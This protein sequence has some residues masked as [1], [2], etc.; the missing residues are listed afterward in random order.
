MSKQKQNLSHLSHYLDL[1][2][3]ASW[4]RNGEVKD[5][6]G[7]KYTLDGLI[8]LI[9]K[10]NINH[11]DANGYTALMRACS[12]R[13][14]NNV[15]LLIKAGAD[16]N[17]VGS[18]GM[19]A[20]IAAAE[21]NNYLAIQDLLGV[22]AGANIDHVDKYGKTALRAAFEKK[23]GSSILTLL[24]AGADV[25]SEPPYG[26]TFLAVAAEI[27]DVKIISTLLEK[28]LDIDEKGGSGMTPLARAA[29][30]GNAAAVVA[31]ANKGADI[32]K[33]DIYGSNPLMV[34]A[35]NSE[36]YKTT[37][38]EDLIMLGVDINQK[39]AEGE[40]A[41]MVASSRG[42]VGIVKKL[43]SLGASVN[44][45]DNNGETAFMKSASGWEVK[46]D[47]LTI[48]L[49]N[50]A[51][52]SLQNNNGSTALGLTRGWYGR[53]LVE[54]TV[55]KTIPTKKYLI[56][57]KDP[58]NISH[59][60]GWSG[61]IHSILES[62]KNKELSKLPFAKLNSDSSISFFVATPVN[63]DYFEEYQ[64]FN[65]PNINFR[66]AILSN[67]FIEQFEHQAQEY[68]LEKIGANKPLIEK[69]P[70]ATGEV[71]EYC[72]NISP[73]NLDSILKLNETYAGYRNESG[74]LKLRE[75]IIPLKDGKIRLFPI[76]PIS[77]E[78]YAVRAD[79]CQ[80]SEVPTL[81]LMQLL[82]NYETEI[83]PDHKKNGFHFHWVPEEVEKALSIE[84]GSFVRFLNDFFKENGIKVT[85]DGRDF[86]ERPDT[87]HIEESAKQKS[88]KIVEI[89][90]NSK[91]F[92]AKYGNCSKEELSNCLSFEA[93]TLPFLQ[94]L[95]GFLEKESANG[96]EA[97]QE[98][99]L[100]TLSLMIEK[101]E[102]RIK[103]EK[104]KPGGLPALATHTPSQLVNDNK[105]KGCCVIS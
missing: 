51:D 25:K 67:H 73:E 87:L 19:T 76:F 42:N 12:D 61:F 88:V 77:E 45:V 38:I 41:L 3:E 81:Q 98:R 84:R 46:E 32:N 68:N 58:E 33:E 78:T 69:K 86:C 14:S 90:Q 104:E 36:N 6:D 27:G 101:E 48:L 34:A 28:N 103:A 82:P 4:D 74:L 53:G 56:N 11:E 49:E 83:L 64:G 62:V 72:F 70:I 16:V 13:R 24:E 26:D 22:G 100:E 31:L 59:H 66:N 2:L 1:F 37:V 9:G 52:H 85:E 71:V 15:E 50:G 94:G 17:H 95:K 8:K 35:T 79:G 10:D 7:L 44:E 93:E 40:T 102:L 21:G 43:L 99:S 54:K 89:D 96:N 63:D 18:S 29:Y 105:T 23:N 80:T 55:E 75:N 65:K 97:P 47:M 20:L 30:H 91:D 57:Q 5:A 60:S 39:N 92:Y